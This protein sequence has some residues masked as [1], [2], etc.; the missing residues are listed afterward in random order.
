MFYGIRNMQRNENNKKVKT[1]AYSIEEA[2][3][4]YN[5]IVTRFDHLKQKDSNRT[6]TEYEEMNSIEQ[7]LIEFCQIA[8]GLGGT[9]TIMDACG[10]LTDEDREQACRFLVQMLENWVII[11]NWKV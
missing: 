4:K 11:H 8:E 5:T 2:H 10:D 3:A 1:M 7:K 9:F 6:W